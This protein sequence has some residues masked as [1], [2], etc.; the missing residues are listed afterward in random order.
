MIPPKQ[1][2]ISNDFTL[3]MILYPDGYIGFVNSINSKLMSA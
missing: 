3:A 2:I 1:V